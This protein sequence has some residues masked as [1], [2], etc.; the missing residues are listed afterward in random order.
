MIKVHTSGTPTDEAARA[1]TKKIKE[2]KGKDMLLL[3]SG[4]SSLAIVDHI[5]PRILTKHCTVSVLDERFTFEKGAGN[6]SK[7]TQTAFFKYIEKKGIPYIDPR[8]HEGE[9]LEET[10]KR[11]DLALKHW[12]ITH[13]DGVVLATIGIG[14]DGHTAGILPI[15]DEEMFSKLFLKSNHCAV[16][17]E[18]AP[19]IN[20][21]TKRITTTATYLTR[22]VTYG[23]LYATGTQK[24][25]ILKKLL[26][27]DIAITHMPA[28]VLKK[29]PNAD[30]FTNLTL[31]A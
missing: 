9:T 21:N 31:T 14:P 23:C 4:G 6:F 22:H 18:V 2:Y 12:H 13:D 11:F 1:L 17:Y 10:A 16:G 5:H 20:P 29:I 30:L 19:E 24:R 28:Q 26:H 7:L 15:S 3:F 8:P 27:E 25:P